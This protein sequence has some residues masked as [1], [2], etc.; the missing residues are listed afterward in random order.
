MKV[1]VMGA[2]SAQF[3][4]ELADFCSLDGIGP[5]E[6]AVVDTDP[7]RLA[8]AGGEIGRAHV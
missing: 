8:I 5:Y 1:V 7:R 6:V 3:M 2:G 4:P